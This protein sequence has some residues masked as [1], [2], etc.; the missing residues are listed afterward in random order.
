MSNETEQKAEGCRA[1]HPHGAK[2]PRAMQ[3]RAK[4]IH[5]L[6]S[7]SGDAAVCVCCPSYRALKAQGIG[8]VCKNTPR[9]TQKSQCAA[10]KIGFLSGDWSHFQS[11]N[12]GF[13]DMKM[14]APNICSSLTR[15]AMRPSFPLPLMVLWSEHVL[16][17]H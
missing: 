3:S 11:K 15:C 1:K 10:L 9:N 7:I 16:L 4:P 6:E 14:F 17:P 2:C 12:E 8:W 13:E 5:S